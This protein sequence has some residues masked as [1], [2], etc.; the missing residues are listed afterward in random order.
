VSETR[1][2]DHVVETLER[3]T[4]LNRLEARGTVRLALKQAGLDASSVTP[5]QMSVVV[6]RIMPGELRSRG[7]GDADPICREL[8]ASLAS[9]PSAEAAETPESVFQRLGGSAKQ[10]P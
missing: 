9:L 1:A 3:R 7:I 2:F 6:E 8:V 5:R 4:E 10:A